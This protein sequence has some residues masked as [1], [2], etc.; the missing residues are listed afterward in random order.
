MF[1]GNQTDRLKS[2]IIRGPPDGTEAGGGPQVNWLNNIT[3]W[4]G[5]GLQDI[6]K[7]REERA[8]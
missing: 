8:E 3:A 2:I 5:M 4:I 6:L 1:F 7:A